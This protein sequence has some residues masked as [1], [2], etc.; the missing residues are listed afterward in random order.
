MLASSRN[1]TVR[2]S[3]PNVRGA[4]FET[5]TC[6]L[7]RPGSMAARTSSIWRL[8]LTSPV[9]AKTADGEK[10][11][12]EY[13]QVWLWWYQSKLLGPCRGGGGDLD[14]WYYCVLKRQAPSLLHANGRLALDRL[15]VETDGSCSEIGKVTV[16][17]IRQTTD[18]RDC[19]RFSLDTLTV[20]LE[21]GNE[22]G[23]S[24]AP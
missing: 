22:I 24:H 3:R 20:R 4:M 12:A 13:A 7:P 16:E 1:Q 19:T 9:H 8:R 23:W 11:S 18:G 6:L 17:N 10:A 14:R 2:S 21:E 15:E 5:K